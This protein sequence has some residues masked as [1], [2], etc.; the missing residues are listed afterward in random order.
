MTVEQLAVDASARAYGNAKRDAIAMMAS[1]LR[2]EHG[3]GIRRIGKRLGLSDREVKLA[4]GE[5]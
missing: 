5:R 2:H 4:T 3:W 1:H